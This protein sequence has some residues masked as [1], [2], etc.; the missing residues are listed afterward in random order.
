MG[1]KGIGRLAIALLGRQVLV[2]T[3]AERD[4]HLHDL[5]MCFIHWGT[6]Y[7]LYEDASRN[8]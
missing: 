7:A 8:G 2:L 6:R 4:G 5:L 1:E 3:R